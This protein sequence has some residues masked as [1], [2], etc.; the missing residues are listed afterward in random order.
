MQ[1]R[2]N[3]SALV[4]YYIFLALIHWNMKSQIIKSYKGVM[5]GSTVTIFEQISHAIRRLKYA[6]LDIWTCHPGYSTHDILST[7][8]WSRPIFHPSDRCLIICC[9]F[10]RMWLKMNMS[11]ADPS[12]AV[13]LSLRVWCVHECIST[14]ATSVMIVYKNTYF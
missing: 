4:M 8:E 1:E 5:G 12:L 2:H 6:K 11:L 10:Y 7:M 13:N 14:M 3:S 9:N